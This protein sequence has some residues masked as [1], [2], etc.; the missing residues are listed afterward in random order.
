MWHEIHTK[1]HRFL[2]YI[3]N[4]GLSWNIAI[5]NI[6]LRNKVKEIKPTFWSGII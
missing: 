5:A 3:N 4:A 1:K 2:A 6:Y